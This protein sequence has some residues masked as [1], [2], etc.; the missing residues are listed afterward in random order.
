MP[1]RRTNAHPR[2]NL[3]DLKKNS[4]TKICRCCICDWIINQAQGGLVSA[5]MR[6]QWLVKKIHINAE[7]TERRGN[8]EQYLQRNL[9]KEI[10]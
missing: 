7:Y 6:F 3:A 1:L 8:I 5:L 9:R 2:G 10:F 4:Q